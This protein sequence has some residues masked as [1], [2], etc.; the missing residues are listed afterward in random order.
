MFCQRLLHRT[1]PLQFQCFVATR[2]EMAARHRVAAA[3]AAQARCIEEARQSLAIQRGRHHHQAQ[4]V[5]QL[6]LHVQRQCQA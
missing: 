3:L 2:R 4:V 6:R 1:A 5:A